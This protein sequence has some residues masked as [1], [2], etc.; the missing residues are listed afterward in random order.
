M[1]E[2]REEGATGTIT[3]YEEE[4]GYGFVST[5]DLGDGS[6]TDVFFHISDVDAGSVEEGWRL[7]F[8]VFSS[9]KG[10]RARNV[11]VLSEGSEEETSAGIDERFWRARNSEY[12][13]SK[14]GV[15]PE[16]EEQQEGDGKGKP[17]SPFEDDVVGSKNDLL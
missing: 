14:S 7:Q 10:F 8:D 6:T 9:R 5:L 15:R 11:D 1:G 3:N 12:D 4:R 2:L 13:D 17:R 16:R